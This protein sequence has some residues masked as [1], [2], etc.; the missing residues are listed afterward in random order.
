MTHSGSSSTG[1]PHPGPP[2]APVAESPWTKAHVIAA[3]VS[4]LVA[5]VAIPVSCVSLNSQSTQ[6]APPTSVAAP[7]P[8][9]TTSRLSTVSPVSEPPTTPANTYTPP[10]PVG[11]VRHQG[12]LDMLPGPGFDLDAPATDPKWGEVLLVDLFPYGN[13]E[14]V[15]DSAS[16]SLFIGA[17][18][19]TYELCSSTTLMVTNKTIDSGQVLPG[20]SFCMK[21]SADRYAGA[22]RCFKWVWSV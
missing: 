22:P 6:D 1:D 9:T 11:T 18:E 5:I 4:A 17:Q 16:R 13:H 14:I 2:H 19:A 10:L 20:N 8:S 12:R 3:I 15:I 7:A 21:T